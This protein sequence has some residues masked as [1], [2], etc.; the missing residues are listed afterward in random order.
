MPRY[1][2]ACPS[3]SQSGSF[4]GTGMRVGVSCSSAIA[5]NLPKGTSSYT[6]ALLPN[7]KYFF[8][9]LGNPKLGNRRDRDGDR[10]G[11]Q[12]PGHERPDRGAGPARRRGIVER[13]S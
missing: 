13:L 2:A 8:R 3:V 6:A 9:K 11:G 10:L 1:L 4:A 7:S 5:E 12:R